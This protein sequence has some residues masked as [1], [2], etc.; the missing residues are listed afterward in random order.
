MIVSCT[1]LRCEGDSEIVG[2]P[3]ECQSENGMNV[4]AFSVQLLKQDNTLI[5]EAPLTVSNGNF[6]FADINHAI[7]LLRIILLPSALDLKLGASVIFSTFAEFKSGNNGNSFLVDVTTDKLTSYEE[8]G[9]Q[10][11]GHT[12]QNEFKALNTGTTEVTAKYPTSIAEPQEDTSDI[13]VF[14]GADCIIN[15]KAAAKCGAD[16]CDEEG[17]DYIDAY[18]IVKGNC[19]GSTY[20]IDNIKM[21]ALGDGC[22][23]NIEFEPTCKQQEDNYNCSGS[24]TID[25]PDECIGEMPDIP[26]ANVETKYVIAYENDNPIDMKAGSFGSFS[27]FPILNKVHAE[28]RNAS[29]EESIEGKILSDNALILNGSKSYYINEYSQHVG[30]D[31]GQELNFK[32]TING[33]TFTGGCTGANQKKFMTYTYTNP[34]S[35]YNVKLE[36]TKGEEKG[37]VTNT[38]KIKHCQCPSS[39]DKFFID[40]CKICGNQGYKCTAPCY[41]DVCMPGRNCASCGCANNYACN[42]TSQVCGEDQGA[43]ECESESVQPDCLG[44]TT[45][46]CYWDYNEL[47]NPTHYFE[48]ENIKCKH[49]DDASSY[50]YGEITHCSQYVDQGSCEADNCYAASPSSCNDNDCDFNG[51]D[52]VCSNFAC[53]WDDSAGECKLSY[54]KTQQ[55]GGT[56]QEECH[57]FS[58][59]GEC[60]GN[61]RTVEVTTECCSTSASNTRCGFSTNGNLYQTQ[62]TTD[63]RTQLCGV[64]SRE[65]PLFD[66]MNILFVIALLAIFYGFIILKKKCKE[67]KK[68]EKL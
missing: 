63:T 49:C 6:Y 12:G 18:A 48:P 44:V 47:S 14:E 24:W 19:V 57:E 41:G 27:F 36:V 68:R 33:Q 5:K 9:G 25:V 4:K 53:V 15:A 23:A 31:E 42:P 67:D 55:G 62:S 40:D 11:F 16:G 35:S 39:S 21:I 28:I 46:S 10:L 13:N 60:I 22:E 20:N 32:W 7:S 8:T 37:E 61:T 50:G 43:E 56:G 30:C 29:D 2:V 34:L 54:T 1:Y 26:G 51:G 64:I 59:Y 58:N 65:L 38:F 66:K 17:A 45:A 52:Y 3:E